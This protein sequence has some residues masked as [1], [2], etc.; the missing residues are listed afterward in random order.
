[1]T[2]ILWALFGAAFLGGVN[3]FFKAN[4]FNL[5]VF[6]LLM[7]MAIPTTF[8]TQL[9]FL[10]SYKQG[11]AFHQCWFLGS[12]TSALAGI[13]CSVLIFKNSIS[14]H[15]ALGIGGIIFSSWL[16]IK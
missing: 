10:L 7:A 16:L 15:Q 6:W 5:S 8:G 12:A 11:P 3:S 4:P 13:L 2:W 1:M 14:F 9:G